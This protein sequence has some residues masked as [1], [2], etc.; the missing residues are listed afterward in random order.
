MRP[1]SPSCSAS[2][3]KAACPAAPVPPRLGCAVRSCRPMRAVAASFFVHTAALVWLAVAVGIEQS[4]RR[5]SLIVTT[6]LAPEPLELDRLDVAPI[7]INVQHEED[8]EIPSLD[9]PLPSVDV[10]GILGGGDWP[11]L[12]ED[13]DR[14]G[15]QGSALGDLGIGLGDRGN[16]AGA[17][18]R[19]RYK[20][21][22]DSL[23][24]MFRRDGLDLVIVFDSTSSMGAEIDTV[25]ARIVQI[26]RALLEKIPD[27]RI[28]FATYKDLTDPPVAVGIPLTND[29]D[30]LYDFLA[31]VEPSG[32]GTDIPEAVQAGLQW[33]MANS[34]FRPKA[35]KVILLF[36]DA[37]PRPGDLPACLTLAKRFRGRYRG[38]ISTVTCRL[39]QPLPEMYAIAKVGGG[40]ALLLNNHERILEELLVLVFGRRFRAD[41]YGFFELDSLEPAPGNRK[42]AAAPPRGPPLPAEVGWISPTGHGG[43][44][45]ER[46]YDTQPHRRE[47]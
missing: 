6:R 21:P 37:P 43:R 42:T 46:A 25:K 1:H 41:V 24:E 20:R 32:G 10:A 15:L 30:R 5:Q 14:F 19:G 31:T 45:L 36:G 47:E 11:E 12:A 29:L 16:A 39:R 27:T 4:S 28:G 22:F 23:V 34:Q 9:T 2:L 38:K 8:V 3:E 44:N 26:G 7:E 13:S 17:G 18:G 33:A 35:R 40:E